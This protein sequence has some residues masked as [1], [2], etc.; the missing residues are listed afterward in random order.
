MRARVIFL[1]VREGDGK[2]QET[3]GVTVRER[4]RVAEIREMSGTRMGMKKKQNKKR[5]TVCVISREET[6]REQEGVCLC[7]REKKRKRQGGGYQL[8]SD[9]HS[10]T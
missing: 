1:C 6:D 3:G 10:T 5:G 2:G 4:E 9:C 8:G 7:A